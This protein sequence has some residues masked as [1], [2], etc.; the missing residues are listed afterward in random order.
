MDGGTVGLGGCRPGTGVRVG[1]DDVMHSGRRGQA[2]DTLCV[3]GRI[4]IAARGRQI[5]HHQDRARVFV[6]GDPLRHRGEIQGTSG[7]PGDGSPADGDGLEVT[8]GDVPTGVGL[9]GSGR[10]VQSPGGWIEG[11]EAQAHDRSVPEIWAYLPTSL[12]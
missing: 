10:D 3:V 4:V 5:R 9:D 12:S 1:G 6:K 11:V 8:D 7:V 2:R